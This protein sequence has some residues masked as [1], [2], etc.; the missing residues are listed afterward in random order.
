MPYYTICYFSKFLTHHFNTSIAINVYCSRNHIR[1]YLVKKSNPIFL[2]LLPPSILGIWGKHMVSLAYG[3]IPGEFNLHP[4]HEGV[5]ITER[6]KERHANMGWQKECLWSRVN[7]KCG[8]KGQANLLQNF[9]VNLYPEMTDSMR[10]DKSMTLY[11]TEQL[12]P[13]LL[14]PNPLC[15]L[16]FLQ[17]LATHYFI[18]FPVTLNSKYQLLKIQLYVNH[19]QMSASGSEFFSEHYFQLSTGHIT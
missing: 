19:F 3:E 6:R 12:Q 9:I 18:F 8:N 1:P 5:G 11:S 7:Y 10:T 13:L 17:V 4:E 14:P 15:W 2:G 16:L